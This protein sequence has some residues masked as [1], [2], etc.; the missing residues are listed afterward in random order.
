MFKK[1]NATVT[2]WAP[3]GRVHAPDEPMS[4]RLYVT[5]TTYF[6]LSLKEWTILQ[7]R[8]SQTPVLVARDGAR[9]YWLYK[10]N[11]YCEDEDLNPEAVYALVE[12]K[13]LKQQRRVQRAMAIVNFQAWLRSLEVLLKFPMLNMPIQML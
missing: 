10:G 6:G 11:W 2:P 3:W 1:V 13:N 8:Q 4:Y 7:A 9:V 5:Q 12:A